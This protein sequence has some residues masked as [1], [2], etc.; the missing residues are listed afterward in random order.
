MKRSESRNPGDESRSGHTEKWVSPML[1]GTLLGMCV[2]VLLSVVAVSMAQAR[3]SAQDMPLSV[4]RSADQTSATATWTPD[5]GA[6]YQ[7]VFVVAKLLGGS[8]TQ[9]DTA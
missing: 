8:Q 3:P 7:A 2:F 5:Q 9:R 6:V 1:R 4:V